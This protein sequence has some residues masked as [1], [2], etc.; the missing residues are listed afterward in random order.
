MKF[1]FYDFQLTRDWYREVTSDVGMHVDLVKYWIQNAILL[2]TPVA[3]HFAEQIW[4][5]ILQQPGSIQNARWPTPSSAVDKGLLEAGLYMR[6]IV[7]TIRDSEVSL[8]K[9]LAKAK[10]N[11]K[12]FDPKGARA[13]RIYVA[14]VF[15]EWQDL[16]LNIIKEAYDPAANKVDDAAVK[17]LLTEKGLIKDKR[18][19]PWIQAFKVCTNRCKFKRPTDWL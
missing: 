19:M 10:N 12:K 16:C 7:K 14:K 9:S 3:P 4:T 15:P 1:G 13:V 5:T 17:K 2:V 8:V 11:V 18:A 6:G